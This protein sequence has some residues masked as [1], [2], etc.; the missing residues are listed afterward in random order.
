MYKFNLIKNYYLEGNLY[1]KDFVEIKEGLT[2]LVGCN[3]SGKTTMINQMKNQ[4]KD[5]E[6]VEILEFN[7]LT[8]G[9]SNKVSEL[10][11]YNR[12]DEISLRLSSS[13][14]EN[15]YYNIGDVIRKIGRAIHIKEKEKLFIFLDA[16]DSGLSIDYC[17]ELIE[18]IK[19]V[20]IPDA[21][22]QGIQLYIIASTNAYELARGNDCL[23]VQNCIY[24]T[25]R[26][27]EYY[28]KFILNS[29]KYKDKREN[30]KKSYERPHLYFK[31]EKKG[32]NK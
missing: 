16:I 5:D 28:R 20:I 25:F 26:G 1:K 11:F 32:G 17:S 4:L 27:Y 29:R 7:N 24:R 6:S 15:I 18:I 12:L 14:G 21:E 13:E 19:E 9:G 10:A 22:N 2:I 23:D 3:G 8:Q 30:N 31:R